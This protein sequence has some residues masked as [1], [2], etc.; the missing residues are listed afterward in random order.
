MAQ[1]NIDPDHSVAAFSVRHL[2]IANVRGQFNRITGAINFDPSAPAGST[3]EATIDVSSITT[4]NRMRDDHLLSPDFFDAARYPSMSF[5]CTKVELAGP[6]RGKV[7][8]D[9]T[10]RGVTRQVT[11]DVEH[12]GPVKSP[13]AV[14][15]E[16]SIGFT[17]K[18][19]INREDFGV[20][21]NIPL[22]A[23]GFV[24][25]KEVEIVLDIEA[26]LAE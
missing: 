21:W 13:E 17:A 4:G 25:G 24:V 11:M 10:I 9:L 26:D 14:G 19:S 2:M 16:T 15:G 5:K 7:S 20:M 12:F 3:V 18:V 1:W 6:N 8:G 22:N 23:G